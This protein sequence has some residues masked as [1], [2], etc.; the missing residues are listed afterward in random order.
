MSKYTYKKQFGI[1]V[2]C[3]DEAEQK[4]LYD[5]LQKLKLN[6]KVVVV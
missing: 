6:L 4:R 2:I 1:V 3:E 5:K